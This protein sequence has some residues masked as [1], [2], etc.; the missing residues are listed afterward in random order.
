[1][2]FVRSVKKV[3]LV[4]ADCGTEFEVTIYGARRKRCP[5]C[6][7][8]RD[9]KMVAAINKK[10]HAAEKLSKS[11]CAQVEK[12]SPTSGYCPHTNCKWFG[13]TSSSCDYRLRTGAGRGCP[14]GRDCAKF[15]VRTER[16]PVSW[17]FAGL[18]GK[19]EEELYL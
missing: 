18:F 16:T 8:K 10:R 14:G 15:E 12:K 19:A 2:S 1:M 3:Q 5:A 17:E 9:A 13:V 6:T 11:Y 7:E 4:C